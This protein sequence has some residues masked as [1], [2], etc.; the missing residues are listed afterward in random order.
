MTNMCCESL[1]EKSLKFAKISLLRHDVNHAPYLLV[2]Y[3]FL[4]LSLKVRCLKEI[5]L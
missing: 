3:H 5:F 1:E 4:L 2:V